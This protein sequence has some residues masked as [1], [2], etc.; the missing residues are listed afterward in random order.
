[1][2]DA[3][4][5]YCALVGVEHDLLVFEDDKVMALL[6]QNPV[7]SGHLI[8]FPKKHRRILEEVPDDELSHLFVVANKL[9]MIV[10]DKLGCKGTN[11]LINNGVAAGQK[12]AHLIVN[13]VPRYEDDGVNF[14]WTP[15]KLGV[16]EM[17][18]VEVAL[19]KQAPKDTKQEPVEAEGYLTETLQ[20]IP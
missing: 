1:M 7:T 17:S 14:E 11:I 15:K 6:S 2:A 16:E 3:E 8:L 12:Q 9:S 4:C 13:I 19:T 20:R 5:A 18:S 10:F